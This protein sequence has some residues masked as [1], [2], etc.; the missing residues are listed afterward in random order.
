MYYENFNAIL[1]KA[2]RQ[3]YRSQDEF[4]RAMGVSQAFVSYIVNGEQPLAEKR[5]LKWAA[6][7]D[8][9]VEE[10]FGNGK[11]AEKHEKVEV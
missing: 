2:I 9:S 11:P 6:A 3:K 5:K 10:L 1:F 4:A 8:S 7:L